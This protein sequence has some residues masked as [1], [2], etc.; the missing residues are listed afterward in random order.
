MK[1]I[2]VTVI[3]VLLLVS[4]LAGCG[5][6]AAPASAPAASGEPVKIGIPDDATNGGRAIKL[7]ETVGLITVNP[8]AG[9]VI[10]LCGEIG[11]D[12]LI[13]VAKNLEIRETGRVLTYD[14]F[15]N[16]FCFFDGGVG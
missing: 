15:E 9:W 4:L 11:M 14:D 13:R 8:E 5:S 7:L 10:R 12:E 2:L 1:K 3:S 6:A 16:H